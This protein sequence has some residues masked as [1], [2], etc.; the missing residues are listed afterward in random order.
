[1]NIVTFES[2]P[3]GAAF[4]LKCGRR[5]LRKLSTDSA[6]LTGSSVAFDSGTPFQ[7]ELCVELPELSVS[8]AAMRELYYGSAAR[9]VSEDKP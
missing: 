3:I 8:A 9:P 4:R 2:L 6:A 7:T 1:M 5:P